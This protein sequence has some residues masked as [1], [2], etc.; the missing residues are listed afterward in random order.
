[1]VIDSGH[2]IMLCAPILVSVAQSRGV[3]LVRF[4]LLMVSNLTIGL[5]T[6]PVGTAMYVASNISGV[7]IHTLSK[8]LVPFWLIMFGVLFVITY[9]PAFTVWVH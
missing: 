6:P 9:V 4:G 5:L 8:S 1:M 3:D 2:A 7:P